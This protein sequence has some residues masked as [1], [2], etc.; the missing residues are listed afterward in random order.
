MRILLLLCLFL[1]TSA[2]AMTADDAFSPHRG[3]TDLIVA[4]I[5]AAQGTI[6]V[7][8]Y[9]FT[10][11]P[12]AEAL[13]AA[14]DRGVDVRVVLDMKANVRQ[15]AG[16][17]VAAHGVP[18]RLNGHYAILHDKFM[19]IDGKTLEVGSFNYTASAENRNA[20]NVLVLHDA[21]K[22]VADY[23]RQWQILWDGGAPL[24]T[25]ASIP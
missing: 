19:A 22:L 13:V 20:E 5:R 21:E 1:A 25:S 2:H 18:V 12:V 15:G 4:A 6:R 14:H 11:R 17:Y 8:A 3:A 16:P 10:S 23:T 9:G 24:M 7:A